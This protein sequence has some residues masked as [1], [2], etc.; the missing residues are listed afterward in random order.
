MR[1]RDASLLIGSS[2]G[3]DSHWFPGAVSPGILPV[4]Y[5][6]LVKTSFAVND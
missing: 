3:D 6:P 4:S 1:H 2:L 5:F